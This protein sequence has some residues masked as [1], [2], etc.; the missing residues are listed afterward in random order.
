MIEIDNVAKFEE[1]KVSGKPALLFFYAQWQDESLNNDL[2]DLMSAMSSKYPNVDF[3][4][5]EAESVLELSEQFKIS[6][7][8]TFV[9]ICG[10]TIIGKVEGAVPADLSKLAKQLSTT[11]NQPSTVF[12]LPEVPK[13][14]S[15]DVESTIRSLISTGLLQSIL[16]LNQVVIIVNPTSAT[17]LNLIQL[18]YVMN[19]KFYFILTP[20]ISFSPA[21]VMLFMKGCPSAPR[22]G[23]SRQISEILSTNEIPFASFDIL[24][25]ENIRAGLKKFS[26]WPT[27]PQLYVSGEFV[28]GLDV[29]KELALGGDL[30]KELGKPHPINSF[31]SIFVCVLVWCHFPSFNIVFNDS[32]LS[33]NMIGVD[34]LHLPPP[35]PTTQERMIELINKS[36]VVIF[37][38]G[39]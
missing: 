19:K 11:P 2:K 3:C 35:M 24:T 34:K 31:F 8:P 16:L 23:F 10:A 4:L 17:T 29:I 13:G 36:K 7:V 28:G 25:D 39:S 5:V 38:K 37:I 15:S 14:S 20:F 22:C 33:D 9:A 30:K 32:S 21:P 1:L 12:K 6:V 27:F 26:D 18:S